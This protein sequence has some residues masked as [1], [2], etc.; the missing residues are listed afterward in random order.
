MATAS[1]SAP[2]PL[3]RFSRKSAPSFSK[4][5]ASF[6][7][8]QNALASLAGVDLAFIFGSVASG[9]LR[10]SSDVDLLV[11]GTT[12]LRQISAALSGIS[13]SLNREINP[14]CLTPAEWSDKLRRNDAFALRV[15]AE[16]K[17]WLKGG[18]D[19]LAAMGG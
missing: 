1:I 4:P 16:P 5:R 18:P 3:I 14:S 17:L 12:G 13:G 10:S 19:A 8:L 9:S 11:I 15:S 2:T 6:P 7:T